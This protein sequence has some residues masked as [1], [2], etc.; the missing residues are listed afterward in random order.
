MK[1][2]NKNTFT[3]SL[4]I[5]PSINHCYI[6][7]GGKKI[8]TKDA[9]KFHDTAVLLTREAMKKQKFKKFDDKTKIIMELVFWF[10]DNR[11]RDSHNTL[12]LLFDAVEDGGLYSN[13]KYVLPWIK[14]FD[15]DKQNPRVDVVAYYKPF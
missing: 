7:R 6:Y 4:P 14:N 9:I 15:V 10:P 11:N 1:T 2:M 3:L 13:D 12:K 8:R 5:P